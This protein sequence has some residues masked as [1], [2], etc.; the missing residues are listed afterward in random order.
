MSNPVLVRKKL[1][2][3]LE[4]QRGYD[5]PSKCRIKGPYPI[6]SSAGFSGWHTEYKCSG[7]NVVTGRYG[8]IGEVYYFNGKCWPL[9]TALFVKNFKGNVPQYVFYLLKSVLK[10]NGKDKSTVP[11]VDRNVL[12]QMI[13]PFHEDS[14]YQV[15]ICSVLLTIDRMITQNSHICSELEAMAKTLYDDWFVQFDFPDENGKPYRTSGGAM[16]WNEKLKR[17]IPKGWK[18]KTIYDIL[19]IDTTPIDPSTLGD[20]ILEHYSIPA[21]DENH[22]PI[23][24]PASEIGSGKFKVF[25]DAILVSKLNPQ[26]KRLWDP[27][28]VSQHAVCSTEFIVFRPRKLWMRPFCFA[29]LDSDAFSAYMVSKAISSTGSRKRIQPDICASFAFA[30]PDELTT[31]AFIAML[32][33]MLEQRK[34]M[35]KETYELESLR[36]WLLPMLMSG[37][38]V[39]I[40][41][42]ER[43]HSR[44]ITK[45]K[46]YYDQRFEKWLQNRGLAARG[47]IDSGTLRAIFDSMDDDDK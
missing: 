47:E 27:C 31:R 43:A 24:Q 3:I 41:A 16:E 22:G 1:G 23:Y 17:K 12:H 18:I 10:I 46:T 6:I 14:A 35:Q 29:L 2:D 30:L 40:D 15:D 32:L 4:F 34:Q 42:D 8:T 44:N 9:N 7:E 38:A 13:V 33:P 36:N 45:D 19:D 25:S 39:V 5:L 26:Y 28:Y 11:G 20:M 37:Q 21:F